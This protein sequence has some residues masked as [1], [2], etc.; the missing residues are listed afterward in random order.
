MINP[1]EPVPSNP[2]RSLAPVDRL[3]EQLY[4]ELRG[5]ARHYMVGERDNHTLQPTAL[6]HE[7]YMRLVASG[8]T[9]ENRVHFLRL[10]ARTMRRILVDHAR[11]K[12]TDRRGG[13]M[14]RVTLTDDAGVAWP[15][16]N[17]I[18]LDRALE[19]LEQLDE[20]QASIVE[21][22]FVIGLTVD[23]MA[24][25]LGVSPRTIKGD[26]RVAMAWLR[27]ELE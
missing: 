15:D 18:D 16:V 17:L 27:R 3:F 14:T 23:E 7:A 2:D 1:E 19:K 4:E 5:V 10:A 24:A 13:Y 12:G 20:R 21:A 22:R 25:E 8:V 6:V 26:T 11:Q 9:I